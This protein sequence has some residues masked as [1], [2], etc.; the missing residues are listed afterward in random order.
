MLSGVGG[1]HAGETTAERKH[2]GSLRRRGGPAVPGIQ[3]VATIQEEATAEVIATATAT[4]GVKVEGVVRGRETATPEQKYRFSLKWHHF[5]LVAMNRHVPPE[6]G[7]TC[8][9]PFL[10]P[11]ETKSRHVWV[12]ASKITPS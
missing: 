5:L 2:E 1:P 8:Q 9:T 6:A 4:T 10:S 7:S 12:G 11:L 3:K